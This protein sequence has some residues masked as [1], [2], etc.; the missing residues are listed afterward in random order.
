MAFPLAAA[1]G[2]GSLN[3]VAANT[4]ASPYAIPATVAHPPPPPS[5]P[6]P[7][8]TFAPVNLNGECLQSIL[9]TR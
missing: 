7:I 4:A 9:T 8:A 3:V 5:P 1:S 2:F 6:V